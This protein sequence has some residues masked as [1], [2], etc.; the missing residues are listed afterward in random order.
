MKAYL[1]V[2][3]IL[4]GLFAAMHFVI[5]YQH[6]QMPAAGIWNGLGPGLVGV[7]AAVLAWW[8]FRLL[9]RSPAVR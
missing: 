8:G 1:I 4:Y 2:T 3:G 6:W 9:G 5:A 7:A